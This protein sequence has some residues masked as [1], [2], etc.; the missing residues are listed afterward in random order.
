MLRIRAPGRR[1][2]ARRTPRPTSGP[3]HWPSS[4]PLPRPPRLRPRAGPKRAWCGPG[5]AWDRARGPCGTPLPPPWRERRPGA[6]R[7]AP[8]GRPRCWDR[9]HGFVGGGESGHAVL[10]A[11]LGAREG[12]LGAHARGRGL[13][14]LLRVRQARRV[15]CRAG[16]PGPTTPPA[17][18]P[19]PPAWPKPRARPPWPGWSGPLP[20]RRPI[21]QPAQGEVGLGG[22]RLLRHLLDGLDRLLG[23]A[24]SARDS[25]LATASSSFL[26]ANAGAAPEPRPGSRSTFSSGE[27]L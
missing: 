15:R 12:G 18:P 1:G 20:A 11:G 8:C 22:V 7:R 14:R 10:H 19:S 17:P 6:L 23:L 24:L 16:G 9:L 13:D 4:P 21:L 3:R 25:A 26:S 27:P 5:G 2:R